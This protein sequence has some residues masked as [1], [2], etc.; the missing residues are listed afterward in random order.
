MHLV[1]RACHPCAIIH[2]LAPFTLDILELGPHAAD[3]FDILNL[4]D[5]HVG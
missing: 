2:T 5:S 1:L 3:S 4:M